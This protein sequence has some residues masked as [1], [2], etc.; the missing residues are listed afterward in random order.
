[1]LY[2]TAWIVMM[3]LVLG[4]ALVG[5]SKPQPT[6]EAGLK[7][8]DIDVGRSLSADK[9]IADKTTSFSP[10]DTIYVSVTTKGTSPSAKLTARWTYESG[11]VVDQSDQTIA[12][13][14]GQSVTEFHISKPDGWPAGAY[15][16][17]VLLDG[18]SSGTKE[19]KVG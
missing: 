11:Q 2:R 1:M 5:C 15:K 9:T 17:E 19:F 18:A 3:S 4:V 16:V 8:T 14:G 6:T 10:T 13:V 12:P 7:V